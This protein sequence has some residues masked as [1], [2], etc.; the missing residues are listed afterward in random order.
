MK[1]P[2]EPAGD[3]TE[4]TLDSRLA[5]EGGFLKLYRDEVRLPDG[6]SAWREYVGHPGAVVMMAFLDDSTILLERQY[7]YPLRRHFIELPAGKLEPGEPHLETARRELVE[8]CG[9]EAGEWWQVA[10]LHPCVGYSDEVIELWGARD[11]R[12][13][14]ARLDPG[15]HLEVFPARV[16]DALEWVRD[17]LVTDTK[18]IIGLL[19]WDRFGRSR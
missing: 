11:L 10:T 6:A 17:G 3:F 14:G 2:P 16:D 7:R 13:V 9:Y 19:W 12:H 8:E 5:H 15:E 1:L 18:T 4:S